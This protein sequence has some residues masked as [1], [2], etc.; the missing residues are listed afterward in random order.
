ME[1]SV[2][3]QMASP[4][5]SITSPSHSLSVTLG[6]AAATAPSGNYDPTMAYVLLSEGDL[7]PNQTDIV[8][9][10]SSNGLDRP[11]CTVEKWILSEDD[12]STEAYSLTLVP[13]FN[14]PNLPQ[15]G[16][17]VLKYTFEL[18][19]IRLF[20]NVRRIYIPRRSEWIDVWRRHGRG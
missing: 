4:V 2:G 18:I 14:L 17:C 8:L 19:F 7:Q 5:Q 3:I 10:I 11:R 15:Q 13:R 6:S 9:I 16:E 1:F 20:L 12:D